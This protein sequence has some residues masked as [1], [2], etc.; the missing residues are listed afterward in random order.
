[1]RKPYKR[2]LFLLTGDI[3]LAYFCLIISL[4][5]RF[6]K[7]LDVQSLKLHLLSFSFIFLIWILILYIF[8]FY[9]I[10]SLKKNYDFYL[11]LLYVFILNIVSSVMFFYILSFSQ[12]EPKKVLLLTSLLFVAGMSLWRRIFNFLSSNYFLNRTAIVGVNK[13]SLFLAKELQKNKGLGYK[14]ICFFDEKEKKSEFKTFKIKKD[15]LKQIKKYH[16]NVLILNKK[17]YFKKDYYS[18]LSEN[19][20]IVDFNKAYEIVFQKI[21]LSLIDQIWF[22]KNLKEKMFYEKTKNILDFGAAL[23]ILILSLPF[24]LLIG[25]LIKLEDGGPIIYSQERV[26]QNKKIFKLYKLRSMIENAE[27]GKA[28]WAQ[29]NDERITS[30]GKIIRK[31]HL[32]ELP[33]MINILKQDISLIGPRPEREEFVKKLEKEIPFYNNR[34]LIKPGFSGWAQIKFRYARSVLDSSEKFEYDLYYFK[35]RSLFLDLKIFVKT[36]GLLFRK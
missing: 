34:H 10:N 36:L 7:N 13:D 14:F 9:Q 23:I 17:Q 21:N 29:K 24:L 20:D 31:L 35:N 27:R 32:D 28:V 1:M 26:G 5:I 4:F 18:L 2:K 16:I 30:T 11:R 19:I 25:I 33:Q 6:G 15:F 22:S 3:I 8:G 12:I